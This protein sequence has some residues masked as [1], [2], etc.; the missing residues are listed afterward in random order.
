MIR[1]FKVALLSV[2]ILAAPIAP[3][4]AKDFAVAEISELKTVVS[5]FETA[6]RTNDMKSMLSVMPPKVWAYFKEKSK[7]EDDKL[8]Q[9]ISEAMAKVMAEIKLID[10]E[11]DVSA[12]TTHD[13]SDGTSYM[14]IPSVVKM[15]VKDYGKVASI[16]QTLAL[17]EDGKWYLMRISDPQQKI[18]LGLVYPAFKGVELPTDTTEDIKE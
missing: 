6:V 2:C 13:L 11:M 18:V 1:F 14:L 4:F 15:E 12:A 5:S 9:T 10:V 8:I 17:R 16:S 7:L 3:T